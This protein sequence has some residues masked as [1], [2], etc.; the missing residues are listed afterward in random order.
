VLCIST[1]TSEGDTQLPA[2]SEAVL[3]WLG[4]CARTAESSRAES[5]RCGV[6]ALALTPVLLDCRS[7]SSAIQGPCSSLHPLQVRA[8]GIMRN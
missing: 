6:A 4:V 8:E 2:C 3:N 5:G 7:L 1:C